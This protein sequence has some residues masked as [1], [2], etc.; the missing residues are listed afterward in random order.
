[1]RADGKLTA[2]LKL[3][4]AIHEFAREFNLVNQRR[5]AA[6]YGL[7]LPIKALVAPHISCGIG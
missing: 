2:F 1:M 4:R 7:S 3:Q 6:C 5:D